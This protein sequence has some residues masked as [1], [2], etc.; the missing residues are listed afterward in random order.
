MFTAIRKT[1][2]D[3]NC[4][5]RALGYSYLESLLGK[6]RETLKF[7]ERVLQTPNDLLAAG[8]EEHRFRN[9]F[10]ACGGAG[11]EGR[12]RVQP[13][14][15]VQ[16]P[17]RLGQNRAVP[18][19]AHFGLHQEPRRLLPALHRRGDGHQGLLR[20]RSGADGHGV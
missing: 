10:N 8:F 4:F 1:K 6:S 3:G 7:K 15:G 12:L 19:P 13:A 2:G 17:E 18:A 14:E 5:Y 20:S 16:R 11:G 9:F